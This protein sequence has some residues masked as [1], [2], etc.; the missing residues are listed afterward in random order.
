MNKSTPIITGIVITLIGVVFFAFPG[1]SGSMFSIFIGAGLMVSAISA[2]I[3]WWN[4]RKVMPAGGVLIFGIVDFFLGAICLLHPLATAISLGWV[5]ALCIAAAG[6]FRVITSISTPFITG[7]D[8]VL[9]IL[10]GLCSILF[11]GLAMAFPEMIMYYLGAGLLVTGITTLI[12]GI[13]A[14]PIDINP[15]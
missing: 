13:K 8:M 9:C 11:G 2:L 1:V 4:L 10:S 12:L 7:I 14:K 3:S 5:V 15:M 6:V